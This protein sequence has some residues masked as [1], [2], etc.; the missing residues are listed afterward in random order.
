MNQFLFLPNPRKIKELKG[1]FLFRKNTLIEIKDLPLADSIF[2]GNR[3]KNAIKSFVG[4]DYEFVKMSS[5]KT[6]S[7][8]KI[9]KTKKTKQK[10]QGYH[11]LIN[12]DIIKVNY[13][14]PAGAFYGISTLIQIIERFGKKLPCIEIEDSPDFLTRGV[15]LDVSRSKVPKMNTLF[16]LV[17]LL[18]SWKINHLELYMEHS[19]AYRQHRIVWEN[20]SPMTGEEIM[21]LDAYCRER[22]IELVPNQNSFGHF[23][24]WLKHPR[25]AHL[26]D[27]TGKNTLCPVDNKVIKL[28][29]GLYDELLPHFTS[30][31]FNVGCD[32][33]V[34]GKGR[35]KKAVEAKGEAQVYYDYLVKIYNLVKERGRTMMFWGDIII[36]HPE[37]VKKLPKDVIALE[38]GY[39]AKHP[40]KE[41]SAIFAASGIPFYV[42][43]GTSSWLSIAGRTDNCIANLL[44]AAE[45]GLKNGAT[46]YLITDWG[47]CG[48]WQYLPVSYLGFAFGAAL[49]WCL[50][51]NRSIPLKD[52]LSLR[53]FSDRTGN[54]GKLA[55]ELGNAGTV[56]GLYI[57]ND[58]PLL[59][60]MLFHALDD[61][62]TVNRIPDGGIERAEKQ[63]DF[64]MS[65]LA[66][67]KMIR[68]DA[69]LIK[70]EF[71][72][73]ARL[74]RH[75]CK[76]AE[77]MKQ[78]ASGVSRKRLGRQ[79]QNLRNDM[80][81]IM[82][83][84]RKLW[85]ARNRSGGLDESLGFMKKVLKQYY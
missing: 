2:I 17:D 10:S 84:H 1:N 47:D 18:A 13:S 9:K 63:I 59:D 75:A 26:A 62:S 12:P 82:A 60:L 43:P 85:L 35:S 49:S 80:K 33:T 76:R 73:A 4:I 54:M 15:M 81:A 77:V 31:L 44:N 19:F 78:L 36:Q 52:I 39:E 56:T 14:D 71:L 50:K 23:E 34:I 74:L 20:A 5:D 46:G 61:P 25:Y 32:E 79:L 40:Y 38:W 16:E 30:S 68:A 28:L 3:L 29:A 22:Y 83:E 8:I 72:N 21:K 53:A 66:G 42:C 27:L 64:A 65:Y 41:H 24:R 48:H 37:F 7:G 6:I 69:K 58:N 55:Y 67:S 11:L 45:N 51:S 57:H 70:K